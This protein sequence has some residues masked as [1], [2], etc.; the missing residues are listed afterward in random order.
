MHNTSLYFFFFFKRQL[1]LIYLFY[2]S[3]LKQHRCS[4]EA[5]LTLRFAHYKLHS[6]RQSIGLLVLVFACLCFMK[7]SLNDIWEV[8]DWR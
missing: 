4:T 6:Y 1:Y 7:C 3:I 8:N 2:N 5:K